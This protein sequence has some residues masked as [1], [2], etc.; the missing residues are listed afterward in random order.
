LEEELPEEREEL[1]W[2]LPPEAWVGF[3]RQEACFLPPEERA[4][5]V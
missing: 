3:L 2:F 5:L 4:D 1:D